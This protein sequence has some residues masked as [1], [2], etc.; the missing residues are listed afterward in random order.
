MS[1]ATQMLKPLFSRPLTCRIYFQQA[2]ITATSDDTGHEAIESES[3]PTSGNAK[4]NTFQSCES[5]VEKSAD[6]AI[7]KAK[8]R[9]KKKKDYT[10][11]K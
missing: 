9:L 7:R 6:Y 3:K 5:R 11:H 2:K 8:K 1:N 10:L 4:H